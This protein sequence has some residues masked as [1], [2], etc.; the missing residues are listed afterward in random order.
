MFYL[1]SSIIFAGVFFITLQLFPKGSEKVI[2]ERL[3]PGAARE[4]RKKSLLVRFLGTIAPINRVFQLKFVRDKVRRSLASAGSSLTVNEFFALKELY[5]IFFPI[6]YVIIVGLPRVN[7]SWIIPL[8]L[9]GL[10]L[11]DLW[12]RR[13]IIARQNAIAKA[14]P[15]VLDLLSLAVG[16]GLDFMVA[17]E[18]MVERCKQDPLIEELSQLWQET[19][20]GK[21]RQEAFRN[22]GRR[23]N[24]PEISSF[25][26]TMVQAD[27]MGTSIEDALCRQ[28]E[29]ALTRRFERGERQALKA[30][31][32][33]LFPLLVFIL[34][35]ILIIVGGPV[36]LQFLTGDI[37][38]I[39]SGF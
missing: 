15:N 29:E 18:K 14:L 25:V 10:V 30:P 13:K 1:V 32:K 38:G 35:V 16:V 7:P 17:V 2:R 6:V 11:P 34:P 28:S 4:R 22:M 21:T 33:L 24:M 8:A 37:S 36:M 19:R 5:A 26:R 3:I 27:K 12:L 9:L 31:I 20:M 23:V 39:G